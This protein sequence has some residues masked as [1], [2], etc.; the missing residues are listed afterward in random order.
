[1]LRQE[2][3][4]TLI[5]SNKLPQRNERVGFGASTESS[6]MSSRHEEDD[7]EFSEFAEDENFLEL[8]SKDNNI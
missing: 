3:R 8:R 1:M 6:I 7:S 5:Q 4:A 2:Y